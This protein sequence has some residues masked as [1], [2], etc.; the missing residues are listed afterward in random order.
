MG[1]K[2]HMRL[3]LSLTLALA[4]QVTQG[5]YVPAIAEFEKADEE[6]VRLPPEAFED[7][8]HMIQEELTARGC[9]IPQAFHT[10]LGKSNVVRG[11]FTQS[12]QT[13]IAV[14]C[15]RERV[16]SILVFRGG[17]EQ[18]VA[19]LAPAPDANYLQGTGDGEIGFLRALGVASP[20][21]IRSCYEALKA[22]GVPDPPPLD[23]EG[24]DDYFVEKAS[25]IWYWH[26]EAWLRLAGAD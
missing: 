24:I 18:D 14:L 21:Y 11:H 6:T 16:S 7:L 26:E 3:C 20:E 8:P 23:H 13:D 15:S 10:D 25:R 19:E 5:Q 9:T 2:T 22:Y 1:I 12:D 17:S 4:V